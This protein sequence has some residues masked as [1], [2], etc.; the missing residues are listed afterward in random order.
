MQGG[1]AG[2]TNQFL[3]ALELQEQGQLEASAFKQE[4][5]LR[6]EVHFSSSPSPPPAPQRDAV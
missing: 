1:K 5:R 2:H 3:Q 4:E 6:G